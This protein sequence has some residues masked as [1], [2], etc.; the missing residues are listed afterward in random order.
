MEKSKKILLLTGDDLF[1]KAR[2]KNNLLATFHKEG[3]EIL[4]K[5]SLQEIQGFRNSLFPINVLFYLE[6]L[7]DKVVQ[8]I[9]EF[10]EDNIRFIIYLDNLKTSNAKEIQKIS[11]QKEFNLPNFFQ[12]EE[13]ARSFVKTEAKEQGLEIDDLNS[14]L[15][16]KTIGTDLGV[17][18]YEILKLKYF[19]AS[20]VTPEDLKMTLSSIRDIPISGL[21][22]ALSKKDPKMILR[23]LHKM[24][25]QKEDQTIQVCRFLYPTIL[26]WIQI[27]DLRNRNE[28]E[29]G[30]AQILGVNIWYLKNKLIPST[31]NWTLGEA[32]SLF[33][34]LVESER[35]LLSGSCNPWG[36]FVCELLKLIEAKS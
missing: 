35:I 36:S 14:E 10:Q 31:K 23:Y 27:L 15:L 3:W 20:K 17:L 28:S 25:S 19:G 4:Q 33:K 9:K 7:E 30:I 6:N 26:K 11:R 5:P 13:F 32:K 18:Y 24:E 29:E 16:V 12:L 2:C 22:E 8:I 1:H 21:L 34:V